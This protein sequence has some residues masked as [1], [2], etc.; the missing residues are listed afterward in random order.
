[1]LIDKSK[2]VLVTGGAGF[3]G[4][5]LLEYLVAK[6][7]QNLYSLD[8]YHTGTDRNHISGVNYLTGDTKDISKY[9]T[10]KPETIFHLGEYSRVEQSFEDFDIVFESNVAGTQQVIR[11]AADCRA[12]LIYAGSS[13]KFADGNLG[14]NQSP[15]SWT[16]SRNTE[17]IQNF[18]NWFDLN[19]AIV[20]FYN[21]Y[22]GREIN[23]GK[24]AT[25]I[26]LYKEAMKKGHPLSVVL[27]GDQQR[28]FTHISDIIEGLFLVAQKGFGD[29]YGIGSD[30]CWSIVD[31]AKHFGGEI[32]FVPARSGN[33]KSA[34]L[35][36]DKVKELGWRPSVR[37]SEYIN[38]LRE[39]NWAPI[40]CNYKK[41]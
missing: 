8:N 2:Q 32:T 24:Y 27:P 1:M 38:H 35:I 25:V 30:E 34:T 41:S 26:G 33:R 37:L 31:V 6:G 5:H 3:I 4:S 28:N 11:F 15:Y 40:D 7:Y 9:V 23:E 13:T 19:F 14:S 20:Y 29:N 21:V 12:K 39:Q 10:F 18:S 36:T 22:G 16:K 17:L